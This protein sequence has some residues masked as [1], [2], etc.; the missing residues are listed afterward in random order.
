MKKTARFIFISALLTGGALVSVVVSIIAMQTGN[1][2]MTSLGSRSALIFAVGMMIYIL[3][4]LARNIHFEALR[5]DLSFKFSTGGW[6]FL[7]LLLVVA[8]LA[9]G[10]AN[11][12][13]YLVLALLV[14]TLVVSEVASRLSLNKVDVKLRFPD[15]IFA[16]EGAHFEITVRNRKR[17]LPSFSV[18]ISAAP[19]RGASEDEAHIDRLAFFAVIP[20]D[21]YARARIEI[22]FPRRGVYPV[23]GFTISTRFPFGFIERRRHAAASGEVVVYPQPQ[24]LDEVLRQISLTQ[25]QTESLMRGSSSDLYS[26]RQYYPTDHPRHIDWKATAK[27]TRLMVREFTRDD[28]WRMTIVLDPTRPPKLAPGSTAGSPEDEARAFAQTFEKT[29]EKMFESAITMTAS[30]AAHFIDAGAEVRLIIGDDDLGYGRGRSHCYFM[31]GRLAR[32]QPANADAGWPSE[33]LNELPALASDNE[34]KILIT[35][36]RR[37]EIPPR[38]LRATELFTFADLTNNDDDS[39]SS[40]QS[41]S[42][43]EMAAETPVHL[44]MTTEVGAGD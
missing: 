20:A 26:I 19:R 27:T 2:E 5:S 41:K 39:L 6:I 18:T 7:V 3:P 11:N 30:L 42:T 44:K 37:E 21:A 34:F 32:L 23:R 8:L 36:A 12:L 10:T 31:L 15:H 40:R 28:D 33:Y 25:G 17:L 43:T 22:G 4:R 35:P 13:L 24:P 38:A 16:H 29:F 1:A 9:F 14:S